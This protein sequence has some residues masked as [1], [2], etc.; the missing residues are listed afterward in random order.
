MRTVFSLLLAVSPAFAQFHW[1]RLTSA[2]FEMY[3]TSDEKKSRDAILHFERVREFFTQVSPAKT[4]NEFPTR[5]VAFKDPDAFRVYAPNKVAAA[6][7][8]AGAVRD[9]IVMEDPS[10]ATYQVMIHEYV[11]LVIR[12]S[13]LR[14]PLWLNEGWAQVFQTLKPVKDGVAVGDLLPDHIKTLASGRWLSLAELD[15]VDT[16]SPNYNEASKAG[17]FYAESWALAHMLYLSPDYKNGFGT[18]LAV[19]NKG[20]T[21]TE[22]LQ[23]AFHKTQTQV[24]ADLQNYLSRKN[25][26]GTVFLTPYE[27]STEA[28]VVSEVPAYESNLMLA[29]LHASAHHVVE[30]GKLYQQL[31]NQEPQRL[32]AF[33]GAGYLD[34]QMGDKDAARKDFGKAFALGSN[35]PQLCL[36]LA[37]LDRAAKQPPA[38]VVQELERAIKL[39]PDFSDAIFDLAVVKVDMRDFEAA[40]DLFGRVGTV[41]PERMA[42]FRS[43]L[44]YANLQR[45]NLTMARTD[46]EASLRAAKNSQETQAAQRLLALIDARSK[47]PAAVLSGERVVRREGTAIGLR[48]VTPGSGALSKMGIAIDGKQMLFDLPDAAAVE[49]VHAP[50]TPD[51]LKCGQLQPFKLIVEYAPASVANQE[52]AG[53][54]R[55][56][57]Y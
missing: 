53:I 14:L 13:G 46:A 39:R 4:V 3:S 17:M 35:D 25:L 27:K 37:T 2:H 36:Q 57:E 55:R 31:E 12:H 30:A 23:I 8:A 26:Y 44:G 21:L 42:L 20:R 40:T 29:D 50:G 16:R 1:I 51:L 18:F 38:Q 41:A 43:A 9:S 28:P 45:G 52:S 33:A 11:H 32:D 56:I 5:I 15:A 19:L 24:Y 6:Y 7:F 48:C 34:V 22:A 47:G 10:P 49:V 54:V